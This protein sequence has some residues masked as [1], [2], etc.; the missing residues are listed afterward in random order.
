M[1]TKT[2]CRFERHEGT[3][4]LTECGWIDSWG[5]K[6]GKLV[7]FEDTG[8][9]WRVVEVGATW[10]AARVQAYAQDYANMKKVTDAFTDKHGQRRLPVRPK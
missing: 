6:V 9:V 2:Q 4:T 7:R 5:A 3:A 1:T 10:P 8:V